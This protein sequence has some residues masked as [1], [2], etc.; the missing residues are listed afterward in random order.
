[1]HIGFRVHE[2]T[3]GKSDDCF[4]VAISPQ[5]ISKWGEKYCSNLGS[6]KMSPQILLIDWFFLI[7]LAHWC[8]LVRTYSILAADLCG[9][10]SLWICSIS[11]ENPLY[12]QSYLAI[13][14]SSESDSKSEE[15]WR[16]NCC[17]DL[18]VITHAVL[19]LSAFGCKSA[20]SDLWH[21]FG[22]I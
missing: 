11:S 1:M 14:A 17:S 15:T 10:P 20:K 21:H 4:Y 3:L 13:N 12:V 9:N 7:N 22:Y 8:I 18:F 19:L 6:C 16:Q 2:L 5:D